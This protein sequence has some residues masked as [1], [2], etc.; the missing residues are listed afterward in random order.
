MKYEIGP[1]PVRIETNIRGRTF[2]R[3]TVPFATSSSGVRYCSEYNHDIYLDGA[4]VV[5]SL[6]QTVGTIKV[7]QVAPCGPRVAPREA[8]ALP[9][10]QPES[11][12]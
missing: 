3:S 5:H 7:R 4:V 2:I 12:Q 11:N 8:P 10:I 6:G 1:E 9:S